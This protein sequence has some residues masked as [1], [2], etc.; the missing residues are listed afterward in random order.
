GDARAVADALTPRAQPSLAARPDAPTILV[1]EDNAEMA[2]YVREVLS[3]EATVVLASGGRE[4]LERAA[5][6]KPDLVLTDLMMPGGSGEELVREMRARPELDDVP[7]VVLTAKADEAMRAK[8]LQEGAQDYVM[9][10]FSAD[11]LRARAK[12]LVTSKRAADFLRRELESNARDLG[13]L[14]QEVVDRRRDLQSALDAARVARDQADRASRVK[15]NFLALVSHELR[16]PLTLLHLQVERMAR[17]P[18]ASELQRQAVPK[19]VSASR[20]LGAMIESLLEHARATSGRIALRPEPV[21]LRDVVEE[22]VEEQR[23]QAELKGLELRV[24]APADLPPLSTD[25]GFVRVVVT[26]LVG[27]AIKFTEAGRVDVTVA[28]ADGAQQISVTD[29]G[30]GIPQADQARIFEP[31]EQ[32]DPVH[33]KHVPGIGLG[34]ALV[35]EISAALGGR[36]ELRSAPGAGSTFTVT[37]PPSPGESAGFTLG[38][39]H[40]TA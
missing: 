21:F 13:T 29:S 6:L 30:P 15:S 39:P 19:L 4:G 17:D 2:A 36:V 9:K 7:I 10:P 27:N 26:N 12:G 40:A 5:A 25:P 20:R 23:G 22:A 11:E 18:D 38:A 1:V 33:M 14:V 34:L 35:R 37:L 32:S 28:M 8:L 24:N 3:P 31:F 16:T